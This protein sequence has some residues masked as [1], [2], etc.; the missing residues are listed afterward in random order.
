MMFRIDDGTDHIHSFIQMKFMIDDYIIE[1]FHALEF[2][3]HLLFGN[4]LVIAIHD[5]VLDQLIPVDHACKF[6]FRNKPIV[7]SMHFII[8][9]WTCRRCDHEMKWQTSFLHALHD[10]I[11]ARAR[12]SRDDDQQRLWMMD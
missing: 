6:L 5:C 2:L 8:T 1:H 11:L 7:S 12:R 4:P 9:L 3:A 10:S